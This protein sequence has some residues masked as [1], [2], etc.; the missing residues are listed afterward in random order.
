MIYPLNSSSTLAGAA[1]SALR[2]SDAG[3]PPSA[4]KGPPRTNFVRTGRVH[5]LARTNLYAPERSTP[6]RARTLDARK[7]PPPS[8]ARTL[9]APE[10]SPLRAQ[11]RERRR[12]RVLPFARTYFPKRRKAA[13][14]RAEALCTRRKSHPRGRR[15]RAN[16]PHVAQRKPRSSSSRRASTSDRAGPGARRARGYCKRRGWA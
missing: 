5:P 9:D 14:S 3:P 2:A 7:S 10:G 8:R 4:V 15:T 13:P 11:V 12:E 1:V 6:S 16:D